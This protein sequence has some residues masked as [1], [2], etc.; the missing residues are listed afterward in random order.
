MFFKSLANLE[1]IEQ[2]RL[3]GSQMRR[4]RQEFHQTHGGVDLGVG[5]LGH[6]ESAAPQGR[7][8]RCSNL[9]RCRI[10]HLLTRC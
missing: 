6:L 2:A 7:A 8:Q 9:G 5:T 3:K 1:K 4:R 10:R